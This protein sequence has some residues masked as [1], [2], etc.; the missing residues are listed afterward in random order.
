L[1]R[2]DPGSF[3]DP[4][5]RVVLG[6]ATV[7]RLLDERGRD[8]WLRLSSTAFAPA[9]VEAGRLIASREAPDS[10]G[11]DS[12]GAALAL[13][14]PRL[15]FISYPFEWTFSMLRDAAL[16]QLDLMFDAL[17]EGMILKDGTPY[18]IQFPA[19][20]P[21]FI[22]IG[23]FERYRAGE[24]WLG[25]RQFCRQFL[26]PLMLRAWVGVPF[27]P[28][29]R[30][31]PEGLTAEQMWKLLPARR[32][33]SPAAVLHVGL[34]ARAE[35]RLRG[36]AVRSS[37][38]EAGFSAD[39]ILTN[40]RKLRALV[41]SLEWDPDDAGWSEYHGCDHVGR[42]RDA[43]TAF[44]GAALERGR[45][46][47]VLDLGANDGHFSRVAVAAGAVAV[48]V[49]GD[50]MVLDRLYSSLPEEISLIPVLSD[51]ANPSPSQGWAGV[52][53]PALFARADP[54]LV[55]AYGL[56]HHLIYTASIPPAGVVDWLASF[57]CPVVVEYV[58][59]DDPMVARLTA[60]KR[61]DEL[62]GDRSREDFERLVSAHFRIA[63][64]AALE[65]GTR[66]LYHLVR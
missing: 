44:L 24:P 53:R 12:D 50:E 56:I 51:L 26:Y 37:L 59:Q 34:Q 35:T 13:E 52:E 15:P 1:K 7:T 47:V 60:N 29:L 4:A 49:D 6:D 19:G 42:D 3:R 22:D 39:M 32:K 45:P 28:W 8:D 66:H 36:E 27:Q 21:L 33:A 11:A 58:A 48:A 9:A 38:A 43:K 57:G 41:E 65:G 30:G 62:H 61:E 18:N 23:S 16:L 25:Y 5:S 64:Q 55:I 46:G 2:A 17:G 14:H 31:D 40:V 10:D 63:D 20:R 54:D